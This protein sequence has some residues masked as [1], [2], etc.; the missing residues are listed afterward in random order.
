MIRAGISR[1]GAARVLQQCEPLLEHGL[2]L[3]R[4]RARARVGAGVGA[5]VG[6]RVRARVWAW[7][8]A[9]AWAGGGGV[10]G[11]GLT[12]GLGLG[13]GLESTGCTLLENRM[14]MLRVKRQ[15]VYSARSLFVRVAVS[16]ARRCGGSL[17]AT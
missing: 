11:L 3:A 4:V 16:A 1:G 12:F 6:V 5:G 14:R 9:G 10:G 13:S 17:A 2:D 8:G 15:L 7:A